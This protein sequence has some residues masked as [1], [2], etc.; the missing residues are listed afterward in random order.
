MTGVAAGYG[1]DPII[2]GVDLG[3]PP[4]QV[5]SVIG[6]NGAGKSTLL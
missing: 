6:P 2:R 5:V 4:G 1:G 3:V